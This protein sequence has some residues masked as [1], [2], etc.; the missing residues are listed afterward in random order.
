[1][2]Y[3]SENAKLAISNVL[4]IYFMKSI[5]PQELRALLAADD[6]VVLIDVRTPAEYAGGHI[7]GARNRPMGEITAEQILSEVGGNDIVVVCQSGGRSSRCYA[8]LENAGA[9]NVRNLSGGT[10]AWT[11]AGLRVESSAKAIMSIERQVRIGA[12]F[13]VLLGLILG[14]LLSPVFVLLSGFVGAG[15]IFAGVTDWCG[16]GL[17]LARMPWNQVGGVCQKK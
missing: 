8:A 4:R 14:E 15:L 16:M 2:N 5:E 3:I 7:P 12:G 13:L 9:K 11:S 17:L 1:L 10:Q 6:A